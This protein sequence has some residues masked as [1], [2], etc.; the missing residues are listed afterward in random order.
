MKYEQKRHPEV[1]VQYKLESRCCNI[2]KE[3]RKQ[4]R[5]Q[6]GKC[7]SDRSEGTNGNEYDPNMWYEILKELKYF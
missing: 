5:H 4:C 1:F 6:G 2:F 3:E 7:R